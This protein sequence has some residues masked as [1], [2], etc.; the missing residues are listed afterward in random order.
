M[1]RAAAI[2]SSTA[3]N[4]GSSAREVA[5][6]AS[7]IERFLSSRQSLRSRLAASSTCLTFSARDMVWA[8]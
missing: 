3:Q 7:W 5:W 6:P 2:R 1:E 8:F 4:S